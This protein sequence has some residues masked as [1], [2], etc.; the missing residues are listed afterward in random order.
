MK[1]DLPNSSGDVGQNSPGD[2]KNKR[3]MRNNYASALYRHGLKEKEEEEAKKSEERLKI[4][5]SLQAISCR[6]EIILSRMRNLCE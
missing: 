2:K 3:R 1:K 4:N 6:Y 5:K